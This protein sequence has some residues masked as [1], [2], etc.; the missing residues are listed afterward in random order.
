MKSNKPNW[1][2]VQRDQ[3]EKLR[4]ACK[5][6]LHHYRTEIFVPPIRL[7]YKDTGKQNPFDEDQ[8]FMVWEN[9]IGPNG[10]IDQNG[11]YFEY[12]YNKEIV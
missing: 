10:D 12:R 6:N 3:W 2:T 1:V 5:E 7:F 4:E 8:Y 9:Y 11:K